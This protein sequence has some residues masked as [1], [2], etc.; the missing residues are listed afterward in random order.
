MQTSTSITAAI[1]ATI[2]RLAAA[3]CANDAFE[4]LVGSDN[5]TTLCQCGGA[6]TLVAIEPVSSNYTSLHARCTDPVT[7]SVKQTQ[8]AQ[9]GT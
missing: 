9:S 7:Y 1:L 2:A 5:G 3:D 8:I 4:S 6:F